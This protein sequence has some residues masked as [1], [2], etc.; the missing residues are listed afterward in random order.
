MGTLASKTALALGQLTGFSRPF[1]IKKVRVHGFVQ[2]FTAADGI[3]LCMARDSTVIAEIADAFDN[4][5]VDPDDDQTYITNQAGKSAV[6][7]ET[8]RAVSSYEPHFEYEVS[9]FGGKGCPIPEDDGIAMYAYNHLAGG[10]N[11][12]AV[13]TYT[14]QL[15]GVWL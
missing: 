1:L 3:M 7:W 6:F 9:M 14:V 4:A 10:L 13:V 8:V 15:L 5:N 2:G 12:G 11:T